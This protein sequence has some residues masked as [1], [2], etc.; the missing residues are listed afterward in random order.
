[1]RKTTT[2][3]AMLSLVLAAACLPE[4]DHESSEQE[5]R[6]A[7][8]TAENLKVEVPSAGSAKPALG[9]VAGLYLATVGVATT[10]N[11][12]AAFVLILVKT[13]VSFPVT[14]VDGDV[15]TWG[16]WNDG[17]LKPGQYRLVVEAKPNGTYA[18]SFEGRRKADGEAAPFRAIVVGTSRP[19]GP[20]RG[21]GEFMMDFDVARSIDPFGDPD[22]QGQ[23]TVAYDL[24]SSPVTL[25]MDAEREAPKPGGG[26]A[27]AT[28]HYEYS[29]AADGSGELEFNGEGDTDDPGTGWEKT[30]VRSRW[31]ATGA[32]RGDISVTGGDIGLTTVS[33]T[34]C[35]SSSFLRVYYT[36]SVGWMPTE[37]AVA[38]CAF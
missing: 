21:S 33:A 16:P 31:K 25:E 36:D 22:A 4:K 1:M 28:F 9:Q 6:E 13:I 24:E 20:H 5:A 8:P 11:G 23:L 3:F 12:G 38:S 19:G 7:I 37:G 34:E 32:G 30:T 26:T 29:E 10:L 27:L 17:A 14:T 35:W 15:Y 2:L 18:W